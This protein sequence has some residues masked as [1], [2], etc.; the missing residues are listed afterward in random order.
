MAAERG[1]VGADRAGDGDGAGDGADASPAQE[2]GQAGD[3]LARVL[4]DV[5]DALDAGYYTARPEEPVEPTPSLG[6]AVA[7]GRALVAEVKR[8]APSWDGAVKQRTVGEVARA[9]RAGGASGISVLTEPS[10]FD[11]SLQDLSTVARLGLPTLMK[12]FVTAVAQLDAARAHGA[13]CVLLIQGVFDR[14]LSPVP[15]DDLVEAAHDRGLEV[16]LEGSTAGEFA[17]ATE[18]DADLVAVNARRL[19]TLDLSL[20]RALRVLDDHRDA[21]TRDGRPCMV[22]SAIRTADDVARA[23]DAGA[24]GIL[25]GTALMHAPDPVGTLKGWSA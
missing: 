8:R 7:Q 4:A 19:D 22:L 21:A 9:Y 17:R 24:D 6:E 18:S 14:G 20:E 1:D 13:S 12:D 15:R 23:F 3:F 11:G 16:L 25:V 10:H 5:R 2:A